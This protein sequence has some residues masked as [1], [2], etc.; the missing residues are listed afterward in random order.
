VGGYCKGKTVGGKE[1]T[2]DF[3]F[4]GRHKRKKMLEEEDEKEGNKKN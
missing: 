2:R 1:E 3:S 4:I